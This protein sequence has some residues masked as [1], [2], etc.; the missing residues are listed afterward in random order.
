MGCDNICLQCLTGIEEESHIFHECIKAK[1]CWEVAAG[2]WS[3]IVPM[4]QASNRFSETIFKML[5]FFSNDK[6]SLFVMIYWSIWSKRNKKL[7]NDIEVEP[8][9]SVQLATNYLLEWTC[10]RQK[11]K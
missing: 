3:Q 6:A 11:I 9:V 2:L 1:Q 5:S 7:Q 4:V 8:R 10:T